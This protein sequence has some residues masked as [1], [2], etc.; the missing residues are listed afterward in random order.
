MRKN[1]QGLDFGLSG[2]SERLENRAGGNKM[3]LI[4]LAR[5]RAAVCILALL[6]LT[7]SA[8]VPL[9][10]VKNVY[11]QSNC[12]L[13]CPPTPTPNP[14]PTPTRSPSPTPTLNP[15]PSPTLSP[16]PSPTPARTA[17]ATPTPTANAR[18]SPTATIA[19]TEA[20]QTP[21]GN[22]AHTP[23]L[24]Q[25]SGGNQTENGGF[26]RI[27]V[28]AGIVVLILF[29]SLVLGCL[30][31][32]R[33]L[34]PP[35]DVKL[36]PSGARPWSR[37]RVP[38]PTSLIP[39]NHAGSAPTSGSAFWAY[40]VP[41]GYPADT[42]VNN[43]PSGFSTGYLPSPQIVA[44]GDVHM[45]SSGDGAS[46]LAD[47]DTSVFSYTNSSLNPGDGSPDNQ[48]AFSHGGAPGWPGNLK[49]KK[50]GLITKAP[51]YASLAT[52]DDNKGIS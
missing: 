5:L 47:A 28:I 3:S 46:S 39:N 49:R 52:M 23:P 40:D 8:L 31:V 41:G 6:L 43:V 11:A 20:V 13:L 25:R 21:N 36:S 33:T 45:V 44:P 48:L 16:S 42:V 24:T 22:S 17:V 19:P 9:N 35:T 14:S 30:F 37:F 26:L 4:H 27:V 38:N 2:R 29:L 18:V 34:L 51:Y 12:L 10:V 1:E 15:S 50:R 32:R 7:L